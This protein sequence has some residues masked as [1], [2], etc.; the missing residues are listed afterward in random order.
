MK[1]LSTKIIAGTALGIAVWLS[2]KNYFKSDSGIKAK[3]KFK[4]MFSDF[5][6]FISPKMEEIK[7]MGRGHYKLAIVNAAK[8]Y[9][10]MKKLSDDTVEKL[11]K[12]T[13]E[14]WSDFLDEE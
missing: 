9:G 10:K 14:L 5:Y 7:N 4:A 11:V 1:I 8:E 12:K 2:L 13:S 3:K 6:D